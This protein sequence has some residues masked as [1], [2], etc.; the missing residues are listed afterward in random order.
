VGELKRGAGPVLVLRFDMDALPVAESLD[1]AHAPNACGFR[2][3]QAGRMHACGH[4][5][6]VAIGLCVAE[7]MAKSV[8]PWHGTLRLV[9]QPAEEGGRGAAPMAAAGIVDDA[10]LLFAAHLGCGL[11]TG[12]VAVTATDFLFSQKIDVRFTG[13]SAHAAMAPQDG[14]NALLAAA[15]ATIG[16]YGLARHGSAATHVNV[17]RLSTGSARN[18]IASDALMKIELRGG[19]S[20][21]Y[22]HML[23]GAERVL[24][25]AALAHGVAVE[26][27]RVGS[28][29]GMTSDPEACRFV[30]EAARSL[31]LRT[32]P[33]WPIGG[34]DDAALL[35]RRVQERGG[36]ACYFL[37]GST[38]AA[39]HHASAFDIDEDALGDGVAVFTH[40]A[41]A[42]LRP[43]AS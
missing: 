16:L 14:A 36:R 17:G 21:A 18:A 20:A 6:H 8:R 12:C 43:P 31:G 39:G 7:A 41:H 37:I 38:L 24:R 9:F 28:T 40:I 34:G 32:V 13:R 42:V 4:D 29:V 35:V 25:G 27:S 26:T 23:S 3:Q 10:D 11:P 22:E 5:G 1:P 33:G 30:E 15:V 19:D 2:S